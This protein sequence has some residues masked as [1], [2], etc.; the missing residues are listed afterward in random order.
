MKRLCVIAIAVLGFAGAAHAQQAQ[1]YRCQ[2]GNDVRSV[3]VERS[4]DGCRVLYKKAAN[5]SAPAKELWRYKAHP[6]TCQTQ[7]DQ[8]VKKLEATG[9]SCSA[10]K[11]G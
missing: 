4:A 6:E 7:A 1:S 5:S 3:T 9:L 2:K 8:F 11:S 10:G